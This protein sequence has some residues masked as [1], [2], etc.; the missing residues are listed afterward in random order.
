MQMFSL[1][2]GDC[3]PVPSAADSSVTPPR[4]IPFDSLLAPGQLWVVGLVSS[5]L[6]LEGPTSSRFCYINLGFVSTILLYRDID[7]GYCS[8]IN[9]TRKV[10]PFR[11]TSCTKLRININK[12]KCQFPENTE[13]KI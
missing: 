5:K 13:K 8:A 2:Y 12:L 11:S 6:A 10:A 1:I 9:N 7:I 3:P 4:V